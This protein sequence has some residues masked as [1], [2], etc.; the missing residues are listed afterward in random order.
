MDVIGNYDVTQENRKYSHEFNV[1]TKYSERSAIQGMES[2]YPIGGQVACFYQIEE[3]SNVSLEL[4]QTDVFLA[5]A[6]IF[7]ILAAGITNCLSKTLI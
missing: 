3:P 5:F 7:F 4:H 2:D 1:G 6:I